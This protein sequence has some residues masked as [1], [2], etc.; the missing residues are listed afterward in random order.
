VAGSTIVEAQQPK[1]ISKEKLEKLQVM[2]RDFE[3]KSKAMPSKKQSDEL[4]RIID[5]FQPLEAS[6]NKRS[7]AFRSKFDRD[8]DAGK[9]TYPLTRAHILEAIAISS[10]EL[11]FFLK[12]SGRIKDWAIKYR[13]NDC[14]QQVKLS[15]RYADEKKGKWAEK[16]RTM[17]LGDPEERAVA[18]LFMIGSTNEDRMGY[19][20]GLFADGKG[21]GL[22]RESLRIVVVCSSGAAVSAPGGPLGNKQH[23]NK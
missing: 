9:G 1:P 3:E 20:G 7:K 2:M 8:I 21:G 16:L 17:P 23:L 4:G 11:E 10:E 18:G 6:L 13:R 14:L 5:E 12:R 22:P 15:Q 19:T